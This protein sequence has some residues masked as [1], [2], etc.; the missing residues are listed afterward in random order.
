MIMDKKN[1][2]WDCFISQ[3]EWSMLMSWSYLLLFLFSWVLMEQEVHSTQTGGTNSFSKG[4]QPRITNRV[5]ICS[6]GW[7][8]HVTGAKL[9]GL[10]AG[11]CIYSVLFLLW[12]FG[13]TSISY[14]STYSRALVVL[15][16]LWW[17]GMASI[18]YLSTYSRALV[19]RVVLLSVFCCGFGGAKGHILKESG[20]NHLKCPILS[21]QK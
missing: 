4:W 20:E 11:S 15:F 13:M 1:S 7:Y 19:P 10:E 9:T 21:C 2:N 16:L 14:L 3:C 12:W 6:W 17:F 18:S 5:V 8:A